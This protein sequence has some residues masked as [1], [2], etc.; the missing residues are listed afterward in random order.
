MIFFL[1]IAVNYLTAA[2][3]GRALASAFAAAGAFFSAALT[4][5]ASSLASLLALALSVTTNSSL[6]MFPLASR[7]GSMCS[8][9][10]SNFCLVES[11]STLLRPSLAA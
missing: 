7:F 1:A 6:M 10:S 9:A 4:A 2:V 5:L 3:F 8:P 11:A